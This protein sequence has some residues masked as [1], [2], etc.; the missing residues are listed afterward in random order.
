MSAKPAPTILVVDDDAFVVA[1]LRDLLE[2]QGAHVVEARDGDEALAVA[3]RERPALVFLDLVMPHRSGL[4][5]LPELLRRNPGTRVLVVSSFD[6][7]GLVEEARRLGAAGFIAK[8]FHPLEI[9][10]AVRDQLPVTA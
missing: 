3:E 6:A 8:P 4:E 7:G 9:A 2:D 10:R 1:V 5:A